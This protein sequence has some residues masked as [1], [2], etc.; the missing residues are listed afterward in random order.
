MR[1]LSVITLALLSTT[2]CSSLT[3][4]NDHISHL[5]RGPPFNDRSEW[6]LDIIGVEARQDFGPYYIS[7]G[8]GYI[9]TANEPQRNI[10]T[11]RV[12]RTFTFTKE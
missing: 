7:G 4:Y 12:A 10:I 3:L 11:V 8:F 5:D 2:G 9:Y 1:R 6:S